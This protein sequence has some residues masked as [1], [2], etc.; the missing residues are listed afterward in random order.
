[1][2]PR[3]MLFP[4]VLL[5]LTGAAPIFADP[6]IPS[7]YPV[8]TTHSRLQNEEQI[9]VCPTDSLVVIADWRDF[10]LGA[11]YRR[12]AIGRSVDGGNT[13]TDD[14]I[15]TNILL[16]DRQSD[17]TLAV[18]NDGNFYACVLDYYSMGVQSYITF[19]KSTDKGE[20][21]TGPYPV[22]H[23]FPW[24]YFEDKQF[25]VIDR[26]DGPYEGNIYVS[27]TR[28]DNPTRIIFARSTDGAATFDD[29]LVVG[30][31]W[32]FSACGGPSN[33]DAGQFSFPLVG[34]DGT[35][36]VFWPSWIMEYPECEW[37]RAQV[38]VKSTDGGVSF[39]SPV[40]VRYT[41]GNSNVDGAVETYDNP[42]C[43]VDMSG[44]PF[45][46]YIYMTNATL[47]LTN[48]SDPDKNIEFI[49]ST[50]GCLSW[51]EPYYVND[52]PTGSGALYDQ[53]HQWIVCNEE[54]T[55]IIIWY[56]QRTDP[57]NHY[58]F[59]VFAAY[60]FDGGAS[61]TTNHRI[62]EVSI[63]PDYL[64]YLRD[65]REDRYTVPDPPGVNKDKS[66][67]GK[68]AE[69]IGVTAFK[70]HVNA[71][72]TDTRNGNQDVYGANWVI[73]LL[74]PRLAA[75]VDGSLTLEYPDF[76][77]A[78][79]WKYNDDQYLIEIATDDLFNN[80]VISQTVTE[81]DYT[82][83][84]PL[85]DDTYYWR[86]KAYKISDASESEYSE[87]REFTVDTYIPAVPEL[88]IPADEFI[89]SV[90]TPEFIWNQPD[91]P[92][93]EV[94]YNLEISGDETFVNQDITRIYTGLTAT[95]YTPPDQVYEDTVYYWRVEAENWAGQSLGYSDSHSFEYMYY[96]CGDLN[97]D[98][99]IN[100]LDVVF[101]ISYI[102]KGGPAPVPL[103]SADVNADTDLNILDVVY[104]INFIYKNG[105]ALI[106]GF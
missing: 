10:M 61:F 52:D 14:L 83:S 6:P 11:G 36:Y 76:D 26:T 38:M 44:G 70:D 81:S 20:T 100:I 91:S 45:N 87:T 23:G 59:D 28:F 67:A 95:S 106:C 25:I 47:D 82:P 34:D 53:F 16:Y 84:S 39:T 40:T 18:D 43:A 54:G 48:E 80:I 5:I 75:P 88:V 78:T 42:V 56:D 73:P 55:L 101:L 98:T 97:D 89:V 51:S 17:P 7:N 58:L 60:S 94:Y 92:P 79:T 35:V 30:P 8:A 74:K 103:I 71:C 33:Y 69:Y 90:T 99:N 57:T 66:R 13:W 49:R 64:G 1:M 29:T 62:S 77:W 65:E 41:A 31:V 72:W 12:V 24:E 19:V 63:N 4:I 86:V 15:G 85:G 50:D 3:S 27:W 93:G 9:F 105:P 68:I 104:L 37:V 22:E 96:I 46:G 32:D 102:Y 2:K 21:W